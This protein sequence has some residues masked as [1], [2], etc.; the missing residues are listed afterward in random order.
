[1]LKKHFYIKP[2][3]NI[4]IR[5]RFCLLVF[6]WLVCAQVSFGQAKNEDE[7]KKEA[8]KSFE[9]EDYAHAYKLYAQLV[10]LYPKDPDFNYHLGVCM[11][12]TEP[13][14]KKPFSYLQIAV[15]N[16]KDAPKDAKFYLAKAY[17][18]N[19]RFDDAIRLYTEYKQTASPASIKKLQVDR[20]IDNCK[21]GKRLL[22][23]LSDLVIIE[24]KQLN[25][26][27]FFRSYNLSDIG[28]KLLVK[29]D[30]F[31]SGADKKKKDK[32]VIY[33][34]RNG[35]RIY[36][37]SYGDNGDRGRDIYFVNKL[38]N[39][40]W[41]KP[42]VLPASINTE[43]D[44]DY[45]FLHPNGRTLYF[46]SKGHNSMGGYDIFKT[47]FDDQ[48]NSWSK[49]V[50][51]DFP[52]NSP[53]DDILFVT[54]SLEKTAYF[55]SGRYSPY[56]KIDVMKINT[57]RR[58][59]DIAVLK[60]TVVK[61]NAQQSLKSK[62]TVKNIENGE[63]V[64]VYQAQ[65]NGDY[66]M[67]LPNG[68][69]FIF[70]VE[71]PGLPTQSDGVQMPVAYSLKPYKQVISYDKQVLKIINYFDGQIADDNY[72]MYIDLIEKK[73]K[74]EVNENDPYNNNLI[75]NKNGNNTESGNNPSAVNTN[76]PTV[77]SESI[78]KANANRNNGANG[79]N[80][81][82]GNNP[83]NKNISN[84][85][86][87]DLAKEDLKESTEE[88]KQL[89][90][91]AQDAMGLATEKNKEAAET[92]RL[93]DEALAKANATTDVTLKNEELARANE[94]KE[95]AKIAGDVAT[96]ASNLAKKLEVDANLQQREAD[97][98]TQYIQELEAVIKNKNNKEA[99]AKLDQLQKQLDDL[100]KQKNQSDELFNSLK[101]ES[102]LKQ[103]ALKA[104]EQK[105]EIINND[106]SALK[107]EVKD[108]E[109]DLANEKDNSLKE[110]INAQ[111]RELN[112]D[113]ESKNKEVAAN[114]GVISQLKNETE[115][116]NKELEIAAKILNEKTD[117]ASNTPDEKSF[118]GAVPTR[119]STTTDGGNE[120]GTAITASE[121]STKYA[122]DVKPIAK[123]S[124]DPAA[125]EKQNEILAAYNAEIEKAVK[126]DKESLANAK[127][128]ADKKKI[129]DEI[130]QLEKQRTGNNKLMAANDTRI[131]E[132]T[133]VAITTN[134][135]AAE[136]NADN[137]AVTTNSDTANPDN[138]VAIGTNTA[139]AGNSPENPGNATN[140][141]N[142][143]ALNPVNTAGGNDNS[144]YLADLNKIRNS[145]GI[146]KTN[147]SELFAYNNYKEAS[148]QTMKNEAASKYNTAKQNEAALDKLI[149]DAE[150]AIKNS[151]NA[152]PA[153]MVNE[154]EAMNNQAFELRKQSA[155]KTG[156][157]KD[158]LLK[159]AMDLEKQAIARKLQ[160]SELAS[161]KNAAK[162]DNNQQNIDALLKLNGAK[163]NDDISQARMLADEAQINFSQAK[164]IRE[165]AKN[166][167]DASRLGGYNNAEEKENEAVQKQQKAIELLQKHNPSYAVKQL[168]AGSDPAATIAGVN[169]E[170]SKSSQSMASAYTAL[171]KANQNELKLQGDKLL[172]NPAYKGNIASQELKAKSDN[173][174]KEAL[175][176]L[177]Q[178]NTAAA[179]ADKA[180]LL[181]QAN[182]KEVEA[183]K[184][185]SLA[186]EALTNPAIAANG[187]NNDASSAGNPANNANENASA[188]GNN[189]EAAVSN[190]VSALSTE[191]PVAANRNGNETNAGNQTGND[192]NVNNTAV[193]TD[194][195]VAANRNGNDNNA[196]NPL[197]SN[198]NENPANNDN[199]VTSNT[200]TNN[201]GND[202]AI[203]AANTSTA[204][205]AGND[206]NGSN[207]STA[208]GNKGIGDDANKL[209]AS[210]NN[211]AEGGL[212][213]FANYKNNDAI[214]LKAKALDKLN[215]ALAE[216][217]KLGAQL[218]NVVQLAAA[219]NNS[220][221]P[222]TTN[223]SAE[224]DQ[225]NNEA[226]D[227]RKKSSASSGTEKENL[228]NQA[229]ALE[230]Q[231]V[232]KKIEA[233][234]VQKNENDQVFNANSQS[235]DELIKL[236]KGK[237]IAERNQVEALIEEAKLARKKATDLRLEAAASPNDAA[238]LGGYNNA[239]E[240]EA[241]AIAR[242]Q[243]AIDLLRKYAPG[244]KQKQ[245][246]LASSNPEAANKLNDVK[247]AVDA[248]TQQH[249]E[250]LTLLSQANEK[251]YK[252]R[253]IALPAGLTPDQQ[254]MKTKAQAAYKQSQALLA[255]AGLE[256]NPLKKKDLLVQANQSG[257]EAIDYLARI[258]GDNAVAIENNRGNK[259]GNDTN[260]SNP[261][262]RNNA[263]NN[264]GNNTDGSNNTN[265]SNANTNGN[266]ANS[267]NAGNDAAAAN[268]NNGNTNPANTNNGGNNA[269]NANNNARNGN[270]ANTAGNNNA[271]NGNNPANAN[272]NNATVIRLKTEEVQVKK[273]NAY[274]EANPIPIDAKIQD[275]LVFKVQ[276]GAFKNPLPNEQFRG[277]TP[278]IGQT[279]PNGYIRYMAG[280]FEQYES[281]D[282]VKNDLRRLG[283]NDAFVVAYYNGQRIT[284][285]EAI[286]KLQA[287][288]GKTVEMNANNSA[289]ITASSNVPRNTAPTS[290]N[291]PVA[292]ST[293]GDAALPAEVAKELEQ[294]NGLLYT[295][296]IGVFSK[297]AT[298]GQ[299][300]NLK[301]VYTERLPN[302]LYRYTVGIYSQT[303]KL[304]FDKRK[305][306]DLG[307][308]DAFVSAYYN[309]KRIPFADAQKLQLENNNL[310][311]ENENPIIFPNGPA[312]AVANNT[313][314][315]NTTAAGN[316]PV[317]T[318]ANTPTVAPFTNGV[319]PPEPTAE[320]GVKVGEEGI[321][322]KVQIGAYKN[323]VPNEV[324]S[325]FL[326]IKT[327]PVD[328][329]VVNGLYIYT[330][331]NFVDI[332]FAKK[333]KDEA[334]S[335][336]ITDA[337]ITVYKD[338]K[339]LYGQE[340]AQYIN[341]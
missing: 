98:S 244:Y 195:P 293:T 85:Q 178:A 214:N 131:K 207:P 272:A 105:N 196:G 141:Y 202:E 298:R 203:S 37:S 209:K 101:A 337:F 43:Y 45:P 292:A 99:L 297:Q 88:A 275:G 199:A 115:G 157:E 231:A 83:A 179:P 90:Q 295:V 185:L 143:A 87:L 265:A 236:T 52:I 160:A 46:S 198:G 219:G 234:A 215:T 264:G 95:Q 29:P 226:A 68:G 183:L 6:F 152:D 316:Q 2:G 327:W 334:V 229:K 290:N 14:K 222:S 63:I 285:N 162:L 288:T 5:C 127:T 168:P 110:N 233:S 328:N 212:T 223:L 276:V 255:K 171:S 339:K 220:G 205:E 197:N 140:P 246:D 338:G 211:P 251:E 81:A 164:K 151:T 89:K 146:N 329:K 216:D 300:F 301:P 117:I 166:Y 65:D 318:A 245:A 144:P 70:T 184:S 19:Y 82:N 273:T 307:V 56:G 80:S 221:A 62:I 165:E 130:A 100:S 20:E 258:T 256:S 48:T 263:G 167:P 74:L 154:A 13:D 286:A 159:Q 270:P 331:G 109:K 248:N 79:N 281:A 57:E 78:D 340:A 84:Q 201:G 277:L 180:S 274:S 132:E 247:T 36:Y 182:Q 232:S 279:T 11:L 336:G 309:A 12:Y 210:L 239:E 250:G 30:D 312:P 55:S 176:L 158:Q 213:A 118:D 91:Q 42:Q 92:Q 303:D 284:L 93:A 94:L 9:E 23:N 97:V 25:E 142:S 172:K 323:Q 333:L 49:P 60:G 326:N 170:I 59:M 254:Q 224:A 324:A 145:L 314:A 266:P 34:P 4:S 67:E 249:V 7:L 104:E 3:L 227:L 332:S 126:I 121:L 282:A 260:G 268:G 58:P 134:T 123:D 106:I 335:V 10:S 114:N 161:V 120:A 33:L 50:N 261:D 133:P 111:I 24:K 28:G 252:S 96:T 73:A 18:Y 186:A 280:N 1:M 8:L 296:Q 225:L 150:T 306:V 311:M 112:N 108:L 47:T 26:A 237:T 135:T 188:A 238:R 315:N 54:D 129:N 102:E 228:L 125:L 241:E 147:A 271:A 153:A 291:A 278:V 330:I 287:A 240:K 27:D 22:S 304:L 175:A 259:N 64:G 204:S 41:S 40:S 299:L 243:K 189:T 16:P 308:R 156:A 76:N 77:T 313:P 119:T 177:S 69:K 218:D 139:N 44:E 66:Y 148:S 149:G 200:V 267:N 305:V 38:P 325:K 217:T 294:T 257:Q 319:K 21:S 51:L 39:G 302:G 191:T 61:E 322:Y 103:Q 122:D 289:G 310:K 169:A 174:N 208:S 181:M 341:K 15:N 163:A 86:L 321:A 35:E 206:I 113:I 72:S 192:T 269:A 31:K 71:T 317:N 194:T 230:A 136:N 242:Q 137:T 253:F 107:D 124:K 187:G 116:I 32:S 262:D 155:A 138:A 128:A 235:I 190:T 75:N 17:H 283:Y 193:T 320:N 53:D 173:L